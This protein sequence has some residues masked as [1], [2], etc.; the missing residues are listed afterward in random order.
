[1]FEVKYLNYNKN[2]DY[3]VNTPTVVLNNHIRSLVFCNFFRSFAYSIM[4]Y[5][6]DRSYH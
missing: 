4:F 2:L 5:P 6:L 1:M 3:G